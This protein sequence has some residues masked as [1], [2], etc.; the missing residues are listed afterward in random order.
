MNANY[1]LQYAEGTGSSSTTTTNIFRLGGNSPTLPN[2]IS[3]LD[4]DRRHTAN[5][6]LDYRLGK[7]DG[8]MIA[9]S[10]LLEN[11]GINLLGTFRSGKPYTQYRNPFDVSNR[12]GIAT[13]GLQGEINGTN[14]PSSFLL[15]MRVDRKFGLGGANAS[16]F[17][18][19]ENVLDS[20]NVV[21]V[22]QATGLPGND[23]YLDTPNGRN[24]YTVGSIDRY[25]YESVINSPF[26]YGIP[27]QTRIGVRL[28]F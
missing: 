26:N 6:S 24:E 14:Q 9:G 20:D 17:L 27:R 3:P 18:E 21:N 10:R 4:F 19:M 12:V 16:I 28:N 11:F 2:F 15:N 23:G 13:A 7:G 5:I 25:Y 8:P 1:T 22:W